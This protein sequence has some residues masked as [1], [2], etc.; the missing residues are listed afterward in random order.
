MPTDPGKRSR[1]ADLLLV[2]LSE[3]LASSGDREALVRLLSVQ[4]PGQWEC[5][6]QI[7]SFLAF[8]EGKKLK[9]PLCV[10]AEAYAKC[11]VRE[12]RRAACRR[13]PSSV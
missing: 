3:G 8:Q 1:F 11:R 4:V 12:G 5:Y 13:C 7:E 2:A 9:D 6:F 10:L